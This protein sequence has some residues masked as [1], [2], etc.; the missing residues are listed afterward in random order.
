[1]IGPS[2]RAVTLV[3]IARHTAQPRN[4]F[5]LWITLAERLAVYFDPRVRKG[6]GR[7]CTY[8]DHK[9]AR[10]HARDERETSREARPSLMHAIARAVC[11]GHRSMCGKQFSHAAH[12]RVRLFGREDAKTSPRQSVEG[13]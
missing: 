13:H 5:P 11:I 2:R 1:M 10:R 6:G 3:C 8:S 9:F 7:S 12:E 4:H